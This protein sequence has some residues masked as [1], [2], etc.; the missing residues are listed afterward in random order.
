MRPRKVETG[1]WEWIVRWGHLKASFHRLRPL[2]ERLTE[3]DRVRIRF[4]SSGPAFA[5]RAMRERCESEGFRIVNVYLLAEAL[6]A[7]LGRGV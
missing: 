5:V 7:Y 1:D 6:R 3:E 4:A 2:V